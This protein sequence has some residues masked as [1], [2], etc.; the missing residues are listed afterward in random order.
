VPSAPLPPVIRQPLGLEVASFLADPVGPARTDALSVMPVW[1]PLVE[2]AALIDPAVP[3]ASAVAAAAD[4][5]SSADASDA[6]V[7]VLSPAVV[8]V[9]DVRLLG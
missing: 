8:P 1:A 2:V 4:G 7:D 9:V 3:S 6:E 5:A